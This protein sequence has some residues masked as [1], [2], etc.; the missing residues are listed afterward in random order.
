MCVHVHVQGGSSRRGGAR[1]G[2]EGMARDTCHGTRDARADLERGGVTHHHAVPRELQ[3]TQVLEQQLAQLTRLLDATERDDAHRGRGVLATVAQPRCQVT[4]QGE[5]LDCV[6]LAL[7]HPA[8]HAHVDERRLHPLRAGR[9][10]ARQQPAVVELGVGEGD[11]GGHAAE[12]LSE[13]DPRVGV[14]SVGE[15]EDRPA[16]AAATRRERCDAP[17]RGTARGE[18]R[19][20]H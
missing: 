9:Q 19:A 13:S 15:V 10:P 11:A 3:V 14:A 18:A 5:R 8:R 16:R 4:H 2:W 6:H 12:V 20:V 1:D 17:T 7:L